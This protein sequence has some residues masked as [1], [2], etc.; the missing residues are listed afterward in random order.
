MPIARGIQG[1]TPPDHHGPAV[2]NGCS[3][4]TA[5]NL[6]VVRQIPL[7]KLLL[8]TDCPWCDIRPNHAS[9]QYVDTKFPTKQ[10]KKWEEGFCVKSRTEPCHIV[11]VAEVIARVKG[12]S[13]EDVADA[14]Y[15]NSLKF[16]GFL[17]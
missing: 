16:Y 1:A 2:C 15:S 17:T 6:E 9:Y 3:L 4:K 7:E 8:E 10:E 12:C 5:E 13:V 14:C 11:Q